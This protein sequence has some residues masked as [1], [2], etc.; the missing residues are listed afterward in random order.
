M[1]APQGKATT[2]L[3]SL[4]RY[5][6]YCI[7]WHHAVCGGYAHCSPRKRELLS[8]NITRLT[9]GSSASSTARGLT[10]HSCSPFRHVPETHLASVNGPAST[11]EWS[12]VDRTLHLHPPTTWT[13][14]R[15]RCELVM[16]E[17]SVLTPCR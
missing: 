2:A 10:L 5:G 4:D 14:R 6:V 17:V 13:D 15:S 1:T 16:K 12:E 8:N 3:C 11:S 9:R 7:I